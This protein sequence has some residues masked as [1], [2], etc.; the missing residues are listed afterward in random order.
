[1]LLQCMLRCYLSCYAKHLETQRTLL[2]RLLWQEITGRSNRKTSRTGVF[3][4][5]NL[6]VRLEFSGRSS[7]SFGFWTQQFQAS[8]KEKSRLH[9]IRNDVVYPAHE[10]Y[11]HYTYSI[12]GVHIMT[13]HTCGCK[14]RQWVLSALTRWSS[15]RKFSK[16]P[17]HCMR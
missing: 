1:M 11:N 4:C 6:S 14:M 17:L 3:Q 2:H 12:V 9:P 7:A 15:D 10:R 13:M 16:S 8:V 5:H